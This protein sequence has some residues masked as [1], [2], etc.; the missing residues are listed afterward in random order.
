MPSLSSTESKVVLYSQTNQRVPTLEF[1]APRLNL[2]S[3]T[4]VNLVD[5]F[6]P[7]NDLEKQITGLLHDA[8][9]AT[10]EDIEKA[11]DALA[12]KTLSMDELNE[13]R[14]KLREMRSM[15]FYHEI[16]ANRLASIKSKE[17]HRQLKRS[18]KRQSVKFGDLPDDEAAR[19]LAEQ[20]EYKRAEARSHVDC[21]RK[22][23][24]RI[25]QD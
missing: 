15:L 17:Y 9:A 16:K 19:N 11:E 23:N 3:S 14:Q 22:Q 21:H 8:G 4:L 12:M 7:K 2:Q 10:P 24:C 25:Q 18:L 20:M 1:T 5:E 13:R 6:E